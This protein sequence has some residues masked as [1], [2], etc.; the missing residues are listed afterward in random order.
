[1]R[2]QGFPFVPTILIADDSPMDR[3]RAAHCLEK[4]ARLQVSF[5]EDGDQAWA[6]IEA[7]APDVVITD[8]QMPGRSGLELTD[9]VRQWFPQVP[10][11]LITSR[12][13]EELA[14]EALVRGAASYVP[15]VSLSEQ[16]LPTVQH[17]LQLAERD[18]VHSRLMHSLAETD[19]TLIL[20]SDLGLVDETIRL[21]VDLLR[22][23]PLGDESERLRVGVG[24]REALLNGVLHGNLELGS[25][26]STDVADGWRARS[27]EEPYASRSL[28]VRMRISRQAAVF[29]I[30]DE[31]AGFDVGQFEKLNA[32][33]LGAA[34]GRGLQLLRTAF[35]EIRFNNVGNEVT[36]IKRC[37][38][39]REWPAEEVSV[40]A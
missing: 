17:V 13:S 1:M 39:D 8:L 14:A 27:L 4:D 26:A 24:L 20:A 6:Q 35:D 16:L 21:A 2:L 36:L 15:K 19:T 18:R 37:I 31:G 34:G 7:R 22:C 38:Y 28:F 5:A 11:I 3:L 32:E 12:G 33:Q 10:V 30:R 29:T 40:I 25:L 9:A 23:L